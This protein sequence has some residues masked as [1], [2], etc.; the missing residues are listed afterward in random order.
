MARELGY[1]KLK[2]YQ[3]ALSFV[4]VRSE[5]LKGLPRRVAACGHLERAAESI[6][7]NIARASSSWSARERI[8]YL[9]DANGSALECAACLDVF[10]AKSLLTSSEVQPGKSLLVEIVSMLVAMW[11]I[12]ADRV[13]EAQE[14]YRTSKGSM[15]SHEDLDV[16]QIVL[17]LISWVEGMLPASACS[18]DLRTKLDTSTT[19]IALNIA[20]GTGRFSG[21]DQAKFFGIAH[22][23]AAQ[24][25][26]LV[27][28]AGAGRAG[29]TCRVEEG[30]E[31]LRL[32]AT[33]LASLANVADR[34]PSSPPLNPTLKPPPLNPTLKPP[35]L[36]PT[37]NTVTSP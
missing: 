30:L 16:Y 15:F 6:A 31:Q 10:V 22:Q 17:R 24:S 25:V 33:I 4:A 2:V 1:E 37:L 9:G 19:A 8:V 28:L 14:P 26:A 11:K 32:V 20:E 27:E 7:V 29:E 35:P 5:L 12:A 13:C 34:A 21:H 18:Y 23:A 36:N 3:K